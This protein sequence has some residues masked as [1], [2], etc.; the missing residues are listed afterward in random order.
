MEPRRTIADEKTSESQMIEIGAG[1]NGLVFAITLAELGKKIPLAIIEK[2][3]VYQRKQ[4][5]RVD[6]RNITSQRILNSL[7][8][9]IKS[10][11]ATQKDEHHIFIPIQI[12]ENRLLAHAKEL[13]I[14][15]IYKQFL[16]QDQYQSLLKE[17]EVKEQK[18]LEAKTQQKYIVGL[19]QI[20]EEFPKCKMIIGADGSRS[21]VRDMITDKEK[22]KKVD[23]RNMIEVKYEVRGKA[24][25]MNELEVPLTQ[26]LLDGFLCSELVKYDNTK[27]RSYVTLT[28]LV[29]EKTATDP[30]LEGVNAK[31]LLP[32][33]TD[34]PKKLK[35]AINLWVKARRDKE[36]VAGSATL[37]KTT[38]SIY[39]S[40]AYSKEISHIPILLVGDASCGFPFMNGLNLGIQNINHLVKLIADLWNELCKNNEKAFHTLMEEHAKNT[41]I[42]FEQGTELVTKADNKIK[43]QKQLVDAMHY[44]S[45][46]P[47]AIIQKIQEPEHEIFR[48]N[49]P[50][51]FEPL[52]DYI[53]HAKPDKKIIANNLFA[54]LLKANNDF[55]LVR[56]ALKEAYLAN[57]QLESTR[58]PDP[59]ESSIGSIMTLFGSRK[60]TLTVSDSKS[61]SNDNI[62]KTIATHGFTH[63]LHDIIYQLH[64]RLKE[65]EEHFPH[66]KDK[67]VQMLK[68]A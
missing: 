4:L 14:P 31:N 29:D 53:N 17:H 12:F 36:I 6:I 61:N 39:T 59:I 65:Y 38:L 15:I 13:N 7:E 50:I 42:T 3:N 41:Q 35:K 24:R 66:G 51:Q 64:I 62:P 55:Q 32:I 5:L 11:E 45:L 8:E 18:A 20:L 40:N 23:L 52:L 9:C 37:N 2:Y 34:L 57:V 56:A 67:S 54:A 60:P 58:K 26:P 19:E 33:S 48:A 22:I 1:P 46:V 16:T 21:S 28:L 44:S 49:V 10:G 30:K 63:K 47:I 27:D 25:T 43:K 68:T